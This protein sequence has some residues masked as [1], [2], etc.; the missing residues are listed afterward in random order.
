MRWRARPRITDPRHY[1]ISSLSGTSTRSDERG[2]AGGLPLEWR[3]V[4]PEKANEAVAD[5]GDHFQVA[6]HCPHRLRIAE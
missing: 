4:G 3:L 2:G 1:Q 5:A 6:G